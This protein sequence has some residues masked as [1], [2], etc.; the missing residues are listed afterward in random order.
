M[1]PFGDQNKNR[2]IVHLNVADFA[3]AV[4]R[5][6]DRRLE[7]RPVVIAPPG[8]ARTVVYDMS[9]EAYLA[10]V[11]KGM[12]L[13]TALRRCPDAHLLPP[14]FDRYE[15]AMGAIFKRALPYSPLVEPGPADGHLF[16]DVTGT[17]RLFGPSMDVALRLHRKIKA[18][19]AMDPIWSV[20][21]NKLV[22]KV[23]TRLVKPTGEYIVS[24]GEEEKFLAPLPVHLI[25][26]IETEDLSRLREFNLTR[27]Y[28]V[29]ALTPAH[30]E[31]AFGARA[32]SI[33]EA[34]RGIDPSP[35]LA[36]GQHPPRV[37]AAHA[38][39]RDT[40]DVAV[41]ES[42]LYTLAERAGRRLR[43]QRRT[44]RRI[45]LLLD[46]SDGVRR[47]RQVAAAPATANDLTIF[48]L[49]RKALTL[50]WTR[51]VRIRHLRLTCDRLTFPPAQLALFPEIDRDNQKREHLVT[52]MDE[53]RTRFGTAAVRMGRTLAA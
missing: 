20:A 29:A 26:G 24:Q 12:A 49:A 45:A 16:L 38:F 11:R 50:A 48:D 18:D 42:A 53:I 7:N 5:S 28:H 19:L 44:A 31:T 43:R 17:H 35:V 34:V 22:A 25:P 51:R 13:Q 4:E 14:R 27:A 6:V 40:N 9:Q 46:H 41:V 30:L 23:A 8:G 36:A 2:A 52:A 1:N 39:G 32:R 3:V 37:T 21:P 33:Y 15:R 47:A 10:G